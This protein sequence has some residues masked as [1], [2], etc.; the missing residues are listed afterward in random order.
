MK[1]HRLQ[2]ACFQSSAA[3]P[4]AGDRNWC[5]RDAR[6]RAEAVQDAGF[7]DLSEIRDVCPGFALAS[8]L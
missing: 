3:S 8:R 1:N 2:L 7:R 6:R 5:R 4:Q